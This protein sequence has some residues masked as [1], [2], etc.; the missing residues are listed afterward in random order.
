MNQQDRQ[1]AEIFA[2]RIRMHFPE[3]RIIAFGSRARGDA[4]QESDLDLCVTIHRVNAASKDIIREI[5]WETGFDNDILISTVIFQTG[6]LEK[7]PAAAG[8]LAANIMREGI[9]A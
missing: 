1:V 8:S 6:Q 7:G 5:A 3:A 2:S 9:A 4:E